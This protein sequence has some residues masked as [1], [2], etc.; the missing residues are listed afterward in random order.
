M[1]DQRSKTAS[2]EAIG[3]LPEPVSGAADGAPWS[4]CLMRKKT[5]SFECSTESVM[6]RNLCGLML[7]PVV[8]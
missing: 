3:N 4:G 1:A 2:P 6:E 7:I 5:S 8:F